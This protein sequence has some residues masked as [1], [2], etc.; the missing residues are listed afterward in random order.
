MQNYEQFL[1][2]QMK[3][4]TYHTK[5]FLK[6]KFSNLDPSVA[7]VSK[8]WRLRQFFFFKS[9][10]FFKA[11]L[12]KNENDFEALIKAFREKVLKASSSQ[13]NLLFEVFDKKPCYDCKDIDSDLSNKS[14][15]EYVLL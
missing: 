7:L 11:F 2:N 4:E 13:M 8:N 3:D 1:I 14:E 10:I 15:D 6:L 12:C 5:A 9:N